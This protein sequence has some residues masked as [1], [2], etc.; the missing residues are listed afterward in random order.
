MGDVAM[1]DLGSVAD[2]PTQPM[3]GMEWSTLLTGLDDQVVA[4]LRQRD[5]RGQRLPLPVVQIRHLGAAFR[6]E[7]PGQGS[8]GAVDEEYCLFA[9]GVPVVPELGPVIQDTFSRLALV[10]DHVSSRRALLNFIGADGDTSRWW[11]PEV[12][13][14]LV[15]A[16]HASD[17]LGII[18][19][20]RPVRG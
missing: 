13:S 2:E 20:N 18:R 16:K 5:R 7:E 6:N 3:P 12:R 9:L 1:A 14:R 4:S 10:T 15:E 11:S 17:P 19:S 8:F